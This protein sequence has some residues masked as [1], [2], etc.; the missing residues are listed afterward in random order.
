LSQV[1][2]MAA[3]RLLRFLPLLFLAGLVILSFLLNFNGLYGQDAHE[4]LRQSQSIFGRLRGQAVP[5]PNLGDATFAGGYPLLA[6]LIRC[7]V[8]DARLAL[9]VAAWVAAA[10]ALGVF[11]RLLALAAPGARAENRWAF[12]V[13]AWALAPAFLRV[14]MTCMSDGLGLALLL[15]AFFFGL[16]AVEKKRGSDAVGA[17]VFAALAISTRYA[18]AALLLPLAVAVGFFLLKKKKWGWAVGALV[19]GAVALLPHFWLKS[20]GAENPL[21]HSMFAQWSFL[22][23]FKSTFYNQNGLADYTLPNGIFVFSLLAHPSFCLLLPGLFLLFKKTDLALP[24]KKILLASLLAY[25]VLLVGIQHQN[26]RHLLP[27]YALL[28]LLLFPAWDR[29]FS[30]GFYFFKRLTWCVLGLLLACQIFFGARA[31][32]PM[33]ARQRLE[34]S[35]AR[36][37]GPILSPGALL[38]GFDLDIAMRSYLPDVQ[39]QSLWERRYDDF[40]PGSFVLFNETALRD[41]WAGK[42]PMLNWAFL[43]DSFELTERR[44]LPSGWSLYE[45]KRRTQ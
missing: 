4:Y 11:E 14:S 12:A 19:A 28:L 17:A 36:E 8:A 45:V 13:L 20:G 26:P 6:A 29:F 30:Y 2:D 9:Q 23:V 18:L 42:N 34:T 37:I 43:R 35:V 31:L 5:V 15:A 38:F 24:A 7:V 10:F 27:A 21:G 3:N 40:P 16:R 33:L 39:H 44:T 22:N 41:Q 1:Y 32:A 25:L